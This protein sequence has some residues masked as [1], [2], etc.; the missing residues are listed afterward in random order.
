MTTEEAL[1]LV[2]ICVPILDDIN[3]AH[4][5]SQQGRYVSCLGF[6]HILSP[7]LSPNLSDV[8]NY[9]LSLDSDIVLALHTHPSRV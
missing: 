5:H 7:V 6:M 2:R 1:V 3:H 4:P 9:K 8:T